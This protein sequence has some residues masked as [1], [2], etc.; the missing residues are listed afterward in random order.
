MVLSIALV[1]EQ[2]VLPVL[3][4]PAHATP[5]PGSKWPVQSRTIHVQV[6]FT[7]D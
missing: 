2:D 7:L 6:F 5:F 4:L 3:I 1:T